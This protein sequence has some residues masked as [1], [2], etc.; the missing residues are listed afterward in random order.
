M[1]LSVNF[2][3]EFERRKPKSKLKTEKSVEIK[4]FKT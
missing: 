2:T 1:K 3:V 4:G